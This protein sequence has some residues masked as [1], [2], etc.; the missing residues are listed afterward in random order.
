MATTDNRLCN[1]FESSLLMDCPAYFAQ[2]NN[3]PLEI[4]IRTDATDER[5][6]NLSKRFD[7]SLEEMKSFRAQQALPKNAALRDASTHP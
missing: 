2:G 1:Q 3:E 7:I 6:A 5:L 4:V